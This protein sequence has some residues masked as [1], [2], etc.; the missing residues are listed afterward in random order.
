M[1]AV[2]PYDLTYDDIPKTNNIYQRWCWYCGKPFQT[3]IKGAKWCGFCD[4]NAERKDNKSNRSA[5]KKNTR[6]IRKAKTAC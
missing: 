4:K 6:R 1:I 3:I 2:V 5:N